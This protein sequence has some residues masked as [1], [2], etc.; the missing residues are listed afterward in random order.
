MGDNRR[1]FYWGWYVVLGA[2]LVLG[3]NYGAR[4]SFGVFVKPM[5]LEYQWSRSVISAGMSILVLAYGIGGIFSGRLIDRIAPRR[6]IMAGST[7][8]A[9]G[10]FLTPF[11][12]EPWQFYI[13][14][15]L[16]G[17]FGGACFGVVVCNSSVGKWFIRKRGVAIGAASIG[18]GAGT[19]VMA[20]LA[21]YVVKV[22]GWQ[23]GFILM[24]VCILVI[25]VVLSQWFMGKT[26]PEDYGLLPDGGGG[27][28]RGGDPISDGGPRLGPS[29]G[30]VLRDS[31]FW[32]LAV[33]YSLAVMAEMSALVHQVAYAQDL[34][35]DKMVAASS[36]GM[37]GM[38]SILGRFFF[39]WMSD[40][41]SDAK[42]AS[43]IGFLLM[44]VGMF[45]LVKTTS[46]AMLFAYA[47]LFGFGYGSLATMMSYLLA[48]RF[49]R[50]ILGAAYGMLNFFAA[51][52]GGGAGPLIAGYI[53]DLTG[54]YNSAWLLNLT[55]L[56]IVTFLILALKP[57]RPDATA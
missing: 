29:L 51:G 9:A 27:T 17:G 54:S 11:V 46:V 1:G 47:L 57:R 19:M 56:L 33:C 24:G 53:Y 15:G 8:M 21:G 39:G 31:R 6:L 12:H 36:L 49:G 28:E 50:H 42:Y 30:Q 55:V 37:I 2:F 45:L 14:Y 4:Y 43:A 41:I 25:G 18:V 34:K 44:A 32:I 16:C 48:D 5:V 13:T 7:L 35:I 26:R 52:I 40:R 20:P 3:I 38:A 10:L 23:A 22:Y